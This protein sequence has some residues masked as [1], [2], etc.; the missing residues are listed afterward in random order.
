M[1]TYKVFPNSTMSKIGLAVSFSK[2]S[3]PV[4]SSAEGVL[5]TVI[6]ETFRTDQICMKVS[7]GSLSKESKVSILENDVDLCLDARPFIPV[8]FRVMLAQEL[9]TGKIDVVVVQSTS[10]SRDHGPIALRG[11]DLIEHI[12]A[13]VIPAGSL[14]PEFTEYVWA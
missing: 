1:I 3:C 11:Y 7:A 10:K 12:G 6:G 2:A 5:P 4:L 13:G 8:E 9:A 14:E